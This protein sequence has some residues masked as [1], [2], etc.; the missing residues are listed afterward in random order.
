MKTL[1][2]I[3]VDDEPLAIEGIELYVNDY[4]NLNL[5]GTFDDAISA[6][7]FIQTNQVD[8]MFLDIEMP[9]MSGLDFL[10]SLKNAPLVIFTTAYPQFALDAFDLNVVDYLLKP[11]G[12]NRFMMAMNKVEFIQSKTP[13]VVEEIA[14]D[15][16]YIKSD[17]KY[18]KIFFKDIKYI[19]GLKDYVIIH[20]T[21]ERIITAINIKNIHL[22]LPHQIFA[23]TSKSYLVNINHIKTVNSESLI[24]DDHEIPLGK[25]YKEYFLNNYVKNNLIKTTQGGK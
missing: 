24:I 5:V 10:K 4:E 2:C 18:V 15:F 9:K 11:I 7:A 21:T 8:L 14:A 1:N 3:I 17:R 12:P 23:R 19:K 20:T 25:V 22:N 6:N 16:I 13:S